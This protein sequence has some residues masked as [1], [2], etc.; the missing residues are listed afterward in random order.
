ML[1][2]SI[3]SFLGFIFPQ[4]SFPIVSIQSALSC[5]VKNLNCLRHLNFPLSGPRKFMTCFAFGFTSGNYLLGMRVEKIKNV[6][7]FIYKV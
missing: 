7:C 1:S 2:L 6:E 5:F 3:V 4:F